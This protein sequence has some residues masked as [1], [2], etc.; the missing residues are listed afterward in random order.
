MKYIAVLLVITGFS[1]TTGAWAPG[2]TDAEECDGPAVH[3]WS[4][5]VISY[6]IRDFTVSFCGAGD[7]DIAA[8]L[9]IKGNKNVALVLVEPDGTI[10]VFSGSGG[11]S[12]AIQGPLDNGDWTFLVRNLGKSRLKFDAQ[13]SFE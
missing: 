1:V 4:G 6:G 7:L 8:E 3:S 13:L 2:T 11:A 5:T 10:H 9:D 12:G